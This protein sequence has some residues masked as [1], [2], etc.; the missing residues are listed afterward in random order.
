MQCLRHE[1]V[2]QQKSHTTQAMCGFF[3]F[4]KN[5]G[6]SSPPAPVFVCP[7]GLFWGLW[8]LL[9]RKAR[10]SP[11]K[12]GVL[13]RGKILIEGDGAGDMNRTRDL[14]ITNELLYRLSYTGT[15]HRSQNARL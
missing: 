9:E 7:V 8:F 4:A 15:V 6:N 1:A 12:A 2:W 3:A 11:L 10:K 14:L 13:C 5:R